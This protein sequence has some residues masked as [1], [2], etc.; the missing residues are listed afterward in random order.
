M[1]FADFQR[2]VQATLASKRLGTPVFVRCTFQGQA[3]ADTI[4]PTLTR[5]AGAAQEWLGQTAERVCTVGRLENGQ[6]SAT[7]QFREGGSAQVSVARG[8]ALGDGIDLMILGNHGALYHDAGSGV[9]WDETT[10]PGD[11]AADRQ[12][13]AALERALQSGKPEA[14]AGARP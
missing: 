7:V 11:G 8:Q 6:V 2:S 12:L 1:T 3:K 10:T 5:L 13:Q 4:L 14:I 9:L